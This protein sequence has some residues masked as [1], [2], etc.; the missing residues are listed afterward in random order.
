MYNT[1]RK[2]NC[3]ILLVSL[4]VVSIPLAV[5]LL[6]MFTFLGRSTRHMVWREPEE[7]FF[8][9]DENML[10]IGNSYT[11]F[12]NLPNLVEEALVAGKPEEYSSK[13]P[14]IKSRISAEGA[15]TATST[16]STKTTKQVHV[17]SHTPG[18]ETFAGHRKGLEFGDDFPCYHY[19]YYYRGDYLRR[20]IT[21]SEGKKYYW[22]WVTLQNHSW[23]PQ[24]YKS[25]DTNEQAI[26]DES[27][28]HAKYINEAIQQ[29]YPHAKTLFIMTW[30]RPN[31]DLFLTMQ[32]N[33]RQGYLHYVTATSTPDRQTYV[34]P[35]GMVFETIYKDQLAAG[36]ERPAKSSLFYDLYDK[37]DHHPSLLGSY[38]AAVTI[39]ATMMGITSLE[40]EF[41]WKPHGLEEATAAT[42]RHAVRRTIQETID[43]KM[44]QYPWQTETATLPSTTASTA[45]AAATKSMPTASS[46]TGPSN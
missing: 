35:V 45:E 33:T 42:L 44:I 10:F 20:W 26:Y 19:D 37:G 32:E 23:Q 9:G 27:V 46:P 18:G 22:K 14:W 21:L 5:H 34:A 6:A 28:E 41:T 38:V 39:Y 8:P 16:A 40:N 11:G 17:A 15:T 43:Q 4:V 36:I 13:S 24:F 31:D 3:A 1:T 25:L 12:H 29:H 2:K 30:G 7:P